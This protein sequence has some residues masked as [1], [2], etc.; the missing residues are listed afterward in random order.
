M[1]LGK[2]L[3][4]FWRDSQIFADCLGIEPDFASGISQGNCHEPNRRPFGLAISA[5]DDFHHF[6]VADFQ[7]LSARLAIFAVGWAWNEF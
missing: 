6:A 5:P 1:A 3:N 7:K 4:S 2:Y